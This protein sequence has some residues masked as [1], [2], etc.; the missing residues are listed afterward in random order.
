MT[1]CPSDEEL[2]HLLADRLAGPDAAALEAH[3]EGCAACQQ[4]LER[5]TA[6]GAATLPPAT[7]AGFPPSLVVPLPA[8]PDRPLAPPAVPGYEVRGEL[9]RGGMGVVYQARQTR[10]DRLVALKMVL[11]GGHADQK[12]LARFRSEAEAAARLAHPNVAQV[13]EVGEHGGLP[14][15]SMEFCPGGSLA[16]KLAGIPLPPRQAAE[17]VE[18]LARAVHAAHA[19]GVVH[20]DLK[21][22]NVL[23][24]ADGTPKVTDFGLAKRLDGVGQT[25]TGAVLGTPS[26]MAPEQAAGK[27]EVGPAADVWALGAILYE[28]LTGRP[29]FKGPTPLD[30]VLQVLND[31]PVP[32]RRLQP[33]VPRDLETVCLKCLQKE[34]GKRYASAAELA[35]DLARF[36]AGEAVR[37][38]PVGPAG[39]LWRVCRRNPVVAGLMAVLALYLV[40]AAVAGIGFGLHSASLA[41][42]AGQARADAEGQAE[43][44]RQAQ[45]DAERQAEES[46]R[47]LVRR[48][49]AEGERLA[50]EGD[51]CAGLAWL[52]EALDLDR[53]D[54]E[55][56]WAHR[57]ALH[58]LLR[59][60]P[61]LLDVWLLPELANPGRAASPDGRRLLAVDD[62]GLARV[63]DTDRHVPLS[64]LHEA[65]SVRFA[66]FGPDGR[67]VLTADSNHAVRVWD[68]ETGRAVTPALAVGRPLENA[69]LTAD[70]SRVITLTEGRARLWDGATGKPL[71][72][73]EDH[74]GTVRWVAFSPDGTRAVSAGDDKTARLWDAD[75]GKS[76]PALVHPY[77]VQHACFSPDSKQLATACNEFPRGSERRLWDAATGE[78]VA[79]G[80]GPASAPFA[81]SHGVIFAADGRRSVTVTG[82]AAWINPGGNQQPVMLTH[83]NLV[84][85]DATAGFSPDYACVLT[86]AEDMTA[87]LWEAPGGRPWTP[88]VRHGAPVWHSSWSADGRS[89]RTASVD[90]VVRTWATAD[91]GAPTRTMKHDGAALRLALSPDGRRVATGSRDRTARVWDLD[92]G[93][94][95]TRVTHRAAVWRV[96]FSPD[97]DLLVTACED[98]TARVWDARTGKAVTDELRLDAGEGLNGPWAAFSPD[99]R[100]VVTGAGTAEAGRGTGAAR[101]WDARTGRAV[102]VLPHAGRVQQA[103][104]SPDGRQVATAGAAGCFVWDLER[105]TK[106]FELAPGHQ[107]EFNDYVTFSPDGTRL[108]TANPDLTVRVHDARTGRPLTLPIPAGIVAEL[109]FSPDGG[110]LVT[111][112][113]DQTA[114][115]WDAATGQPLT[116]PLRHRSLVAGASFSTDGNFVVTASQEGGRVWDAATGRLLTVPFLAGRGGG[117]GKAALTP[118]NRRVVTADHDELV[119]VWDDVLSAGDE[120]TAD[121]VLRARLVAGLRVDAGSGLAP[122]E[123]AALRDGWA[124]LHPGAGPASPE[125]P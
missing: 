96:A 52:A 112:G 111:A 13:Y 22:G 107:D 62:A 77:R 90:G 29:P 72:G 26:Y 67:L 83:A 124:A 81:S 31:E 14:F 95:L 121:L 68:A 34:P 12:E 33:G 116:P 2:R 20:R 30:T 113:R 103:E 25:A 89:W 73:M 19:A 49:V 75:T 117:W 42:K 110:R 41:E 43:K 3:V 104:V 39:R 61:E 6:A 114:R 50:G 36:Q 71:P 27:K 70:G 88:P 98:G 44:A 82:T 35:D 5:L 78:L 57:V 123:P 60:A 38:R 63:W 21:P 9:G 101:V 66:A 18:T 91:C 80:G 23:L 16:Q 87:R 1:R 74:G 32:P 97:G 53:G 51:V 54:P 106:L 122:L 115:V 46:R 86:V 93:Q 108:A 92:T 109:A 17:L 15:F 65:G 45:A 24:A 8:S 37:A 76:G 59:Q 7:G 11:A 100:Y 120:P 105:G 118:D 10:A 55:R 48:S 119:R 125:R 58:S 84:R 47:L 56:E 85:R 79:R 94:E 99:G 69:V 64:P 28:C 40:G 102:T 4:A